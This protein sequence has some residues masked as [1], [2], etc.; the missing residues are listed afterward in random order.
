MVAG[1]HPDVHDFGDLP[2]VDEQPDEDADLHHEVGLVVQDVE[3]HH[4]GL[5]HTEYDGAHRQ[6]LQ[7]LATVP[8]LDV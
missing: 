4:Q 8:E 3:E 5:E 1:A 7:R 6:P 2:E